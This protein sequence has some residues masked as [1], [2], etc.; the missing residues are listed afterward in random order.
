MKEE[1][2]LEYD[3]KY[4]AD[5]VKYPHAVQSSKLRKATDEEV[6]KA[7]SEY[8]KTKRCDHSFMID[9][10]AWMYDFRHCAICGRGLGAV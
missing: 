2:Y 9:E 8:S 6:N 3:R 7:R 5:P 10:S 1:I 4:V